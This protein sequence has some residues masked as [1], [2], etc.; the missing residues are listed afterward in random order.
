M[1]NVINLVVQKDRCIGCSVCAGICPAD[2]LEMKFN[3]S[4][5]LQPVLVGKCLE[6]CDIC[7]KNCPFNEIISTE[8]GL[9]NFVKTYEFSLKNDEK[10][11]KSASGGAGNYILTGIL[12]RKLA[13]KIISVR[14]GEKYLFEFG[15]FDD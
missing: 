9:G 6:K 1:K 2:A 3:E 11:L 4:G 15:V 10:R 8:Q 5:N 7:I 14:Q 13:D 12:K